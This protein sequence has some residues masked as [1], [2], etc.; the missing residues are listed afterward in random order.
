MKFLN[1]GFEYKR[2]II[3]K[4]KYSHILIKEFANTSNI[5]VVEL[6]KLC[7]LVCKLLQFPRKIAVIHFYTSCLFKKVYL[8]I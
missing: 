7:N 6:K 1:V 5:L 2:K 4:V 3:H 8:R